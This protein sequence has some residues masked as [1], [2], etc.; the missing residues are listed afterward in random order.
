MADPGSALARKGLGGATPKARHVRNPTLHSLLQE[1]TSDVGAELTQVADQGDQIPFEVTESGASGRGGVPLYCYRA[2][3]GDFIRARRDLLASLA[4]YVPAVGALENAGS[5]DLYLGARG[6]SVVPEDARQRADA[7]LRSFVAR[8]FD[9]R[10]SFDFDPERFEVAYGELERALYRGRCV[11]EVIAPLRGLDLDPEATELNLG[12]GLLLI[13]PDAI[14]G[15]PPELD[16]EIESS[17]AAPALL[18]VLRSAHEWPQQPPVANA[19]SRFRR[20]L[21]ALRLFEPGGYS[22]GPSCYARVDGGAW[23]RVALGQSVRPRMITRI[24][25]DQEDELRAFTSLVARRVPATFAAARNAGEQPLPDGSGA[26]ELAWALARF[27]MGCERLAPFEALTDYLLALRALLEPEG[28]ASGRL[29]QRLAVICAPPEG[30]G[31]L[32]E[33]TAQAITLE[34]SVIAGL[35]AASPG[36]GALVDELAE[37]LR[38]ILRDVLCGHLDADVRGMADELLAEAAEKSVA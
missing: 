12:G 28:P 10:S 25:R 24:A 1:F 23:T 5:T 6:E 4:S 8:V 20:V 19:R 2:L 7:A 32:A 16:A 18:I 11:T 26:G 3:T 27:E 13:R 33:R 31:Q 22:I 17:S 30:R 21:T 15:A 37:H 35:A 9:E 14:V 34:R 38:A 29:A 36:V